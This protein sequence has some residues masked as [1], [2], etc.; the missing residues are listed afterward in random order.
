MTC[1]HSLA[2]LYHVRRHEPSLIGAVVLGLIW[3][4]FA[5]GLALAKWIGG[6]IIT[7]E[8]YHY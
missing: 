6:K 1:I 8:N 4:L 7:D 5:P 2:L 3:L